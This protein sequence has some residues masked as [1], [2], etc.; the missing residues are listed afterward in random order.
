MN[1]SCY[2]DRWRYYWLRMDKLLLLYNDTDDLFCMITIQY[3]FWFY[4]FIILCIRQQSR[5][6]VWRMLK[7]SAKLLAI[8]QVHLWAC[9]C[10]LVSVVMWRNLCD[11]YFEKQIDLAEKT[12]LPMFLHCRA[13]ALDLT[14]IVTRHRPRISGAVVSVQNIN[15]TFRCF[16]IISEMSMVSRGLPVRLS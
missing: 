13:A 6:I 2:A 14:E 1:F 11:R 4:L 8:F 5:T 9:N 10:S 3:Y 7:Q 12:K 15:C 16:V